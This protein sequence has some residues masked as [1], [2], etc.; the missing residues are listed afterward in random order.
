M[1]KPHKRQRPAVVDYAVILGLWVAM[2]AYLTSGGP[3]YPP[4][5]Q[6]YRHA[7]LTRNPV[8]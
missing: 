7:I 8:R 5:P 3:Y 1:M 6:T 2:L 4:G